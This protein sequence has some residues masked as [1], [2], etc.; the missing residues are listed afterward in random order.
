[1]HALVPGSRRVLL[2]E[3]ETADGLAEAARVYGDFLD[4]I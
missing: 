2:K 1:M 4:A 3:L